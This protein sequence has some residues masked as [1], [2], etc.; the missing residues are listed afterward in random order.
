MVAPK[1]AM[2]AIAKA[3]ADSG[4]LPSSMGLLLQEADASLEDANTD[5]PLLE[6]QPVT[7]DHVAISNTD[8]VGFVTDE[9]GNHAGRVY[10]SEYEMVVQIDIWTIEQ[11]GHDVDELGQSL[12]R[13]LY[14]YSDYGPGE[15]FVTPDGDP[16]EDIHYF[17]IL[18]GERTDDL[19]TSPTVRKWSHEVEL[20]GQEQFVTSEDYIMDVDYPSADELEST[21]EEVII[22]NISG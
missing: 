20:W 9:Y 17:K 15:D 7:V 6:I 2:N 21:D 16:I 3:I 14:P 8:F 5:V 1:D 22:E 10:S 11:D 13:S 4:E 18:S 12:R 19:V